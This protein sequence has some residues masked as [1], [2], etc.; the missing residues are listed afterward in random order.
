MGKRGPDTEHSPVGT[1]VVSPESASRCEA[2]R[3]ACRRSVHA[4]R[5]CWPEHLWRRGDEGPAAS[6]LA[7][8]GVAA[9]RAAVTGTD[10]TWRR[11]R[12]FVV[13]FPV[14]LGG[15]FQSPLLVVLL[16]CS[17]DLALGDLFGEI[18]GNPLWFFGL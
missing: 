3:A 5:E 7:G 9:T 11:A 1:A 14:V 6:V 15:V 17:R 8:V 10:P 13:L 2:M 16:G 4:C 18:C 12:K